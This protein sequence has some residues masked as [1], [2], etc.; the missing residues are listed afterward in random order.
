MSN[1]I[2]NEKIVITTTPSGHEKSINVIHVKGTGDGPHVH[3]QSSVHGSELQGN[4]VIH[5]LLSYLKKHEINGSMTIIPLAN[6]MAT[7][8][9]VST[10]TQGRFHP[11]TGENWNRL[12]QDITN[13]LNLDEIIGAKDIKKVAK[14][15]IQNA[16]TKVYNT[17]SEY[18]H[19]SSSFL[20]YKLQSLA[21]KADI[22]LDLHTG[23][24]ATDYLY[25]R[26]DNKERSRDLNFPHTILITNLFAGAMDEASFMPWYTIEKHMQEA[27]IISNNLFEVYTIELGSE[28]YI[29]SQKAKNQSQNILSFLS[30]RAVVNESIKIQNCSFYE[31]DL[32]NFVSYNTPK[33]GLV[34]YLKAPGEE[35]LK[36]EPLY[37]IFLS[38]DLGFKE[39]EVLAV[40]S[41]IVINHAPSS[42]LSRGTCVYQVLNRNL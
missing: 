33:G 21:S 30:K 23:P 18:G 11:E 13:E 12:Y 32:E 24:I 15:S 4:L 37:K 29:S 5:N 38:D 40:E 35:I 20:A 6:P 10:F 22:V 7:D 39:E 1:T 19:K 17:N 42:A 3:I 9:K 34:E 28:E 16:L 31:S 26:K 41:G 27:N 8:N 2:S 36:G 14:E 25:A